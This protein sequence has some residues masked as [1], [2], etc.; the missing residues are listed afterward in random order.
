MREIEQIDE[1]KHK[2]DQARALAIA[3]GGGVLAYLIE[4]A[5]LEAEETKKSAEAAARRPHNDG[6]E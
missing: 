1:T 6:R 3:V 5:I 2:L 4:I